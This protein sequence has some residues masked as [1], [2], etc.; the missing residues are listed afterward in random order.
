VASAMFAY[1]GIARKKI[2]IFWSF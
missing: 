1:M 2:I